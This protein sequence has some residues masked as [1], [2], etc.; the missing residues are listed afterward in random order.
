MK[1]DLARQFGFVRRWML[2]G[3]LPD[4]DGK[5]L[6][7]THPVE[8]GVDFAAS[9]TGKGDRPVRWQEHRTTDDYGVVDLAKVLGQDR[10]VL[11]YACAVLES[12]CEQHVEVRVGSNNAVQ[13]FLNGKRILSRAIGHQG[14]RMD[15]NVGRGVLKAGRNEILVK[16]Y[17][18]DHVQF[19][20]Q[21]SFQLR[22]CDRLGRLSVADVAPVAGGPRG[23]QP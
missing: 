8:K 23:K 22:L 10:A 18:D 15:Q 1:I 7:M 2:L 6:E 20:K 16:V 13:V 17:R 12:K 5:G 11:G 14:M 4:A 19:S 21:W 3:P 9:F